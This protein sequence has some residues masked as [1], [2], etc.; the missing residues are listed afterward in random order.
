MHIVGTVLVICYNP[1]IRKFYV[2]NLTVRGYPTIGLISMRREDSE[3][4]KNCLL[5]QVTPDLVLMW[6]ALA[7]LEPD[8]ENIRQS[9]ADSVPIIVVSDERPAPEWMTKWKIADHR[10]GLSDGRKLMNFLQ[11]WLN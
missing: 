6:G 9:Y 3:P 10:S 7:A 11:R 2:D 8:I 1:N 5:G 4:S